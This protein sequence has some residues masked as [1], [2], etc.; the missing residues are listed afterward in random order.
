MA[1]VPVAGWLSV[2]WMVLATILC[3][4]VTVG[5]IKL[6]DHDGLRSRGPWWWLIV[7]LVLTLLMSANLVWKLCDDPQH[8]TPAYMIQQT[9]KILFTSWICC[10]VVSQIW[11]LMLKHKFSHAVEDF[12]KSGVWQL[13][14]LSAAHIW[15]KDQRVKFVGTSFCVYTSVA[16]FGVSLVAPDIERRIKQT[17]LVLGAVM[18]VSAISATVCFWFLRQSSFSDSPT[19]EILIVNI[20]CYSGVLEIVLASLAE[21][22][23][24]LV[25]TSFTLWYFLVF[26]L[27]VKVAIVVW[28]LWGVY[29]LETH[30]LAHV[31]KTSLSEFAKFISNP[32]NTA[33]FM[34]FLA[35]EFSSENL[36]FL[37]QARLHQSLFCYSIDHK[38]AYESCKAICQIYVC[39]N[40]HLQVNLSGAVRQAILSKMEEYEL[41]QLA[42][43]KVVSPVQT[44]TNKK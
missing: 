11:I 14:R 28:P 27:I 17:Q 23:P 29:K 5:L 37:K 2:A 8:N 35:H 13:T 25:M 21:G 34:K 1:S 12:Q 22:E 24:H 20:F 26:V 15:I 31:D 38:K 16:L 42:P 6:R 44:K 18:L 33:D 4:F 36:L 40:A 7:I 9:T 3:C 43:S 19:I 41:S 30:L 39:N 10:A 32:L